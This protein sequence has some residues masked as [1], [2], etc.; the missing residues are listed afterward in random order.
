M[1]LTPETGKMRPRSVISPAT[2]MSGFTHA[3]SS[4]EATAMKMGT[5][6]LAASR[7]E[8]PRGTCTCRSMVFKN[9]GASRSVSARERTNES[10]V[11][12]DSFMTLRSP[13]VTVI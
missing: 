4:S 6:A 3:S 8:P 2:A 11:A 5:P 12:A 10:A 9:S 7:E 1:A 13:P